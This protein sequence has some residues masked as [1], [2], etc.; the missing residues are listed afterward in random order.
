MA[1]AKSIYVIGKVVTVHLAKTPENEN[2]H[3]SQ[4]N[5]EVKNGWSC[6]STLYGLLACT[7]L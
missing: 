5:A 1:T 2:D 4:S 3:P 7:T 6:N